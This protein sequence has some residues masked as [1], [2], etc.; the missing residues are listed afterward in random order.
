M[1]QQP[2]GPRPALVGEPDDV[3][4]RPGGDAAHDEV[5]A[6]GGGEHGGPPL[7]GQVG[8]DG[9]EPAGQRRVQERLR[10]VHQDEPVVRAGQHG[11]DAGV[12]LHPVAELFDGRSSSVECP[13]AVVEGLLLCRVSRRTTRHP[14]PHVAGVGRI[15]SK[16]QT[17]RIAGVRSHAAAGSVVFEQG[18]EVIYGRLS[19][20]AER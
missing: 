17:E 4:P 5:D 1:R 14:D 13:R 11:D 15:E 10:L 7:G 8:H 20:I 18:G 19:Q 3:H 6:V 16:V 2:G 9:A 12:R